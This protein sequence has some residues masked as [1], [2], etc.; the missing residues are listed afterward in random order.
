MTTILLTVSVQAA[1]LYDVTVNVVDENYSPVANTTVTVLQNSIVV[2]TGVTDVSGNVVFQLSEGL[3]V[4]QADI[5]GVTCS[6]EQYINGDVGIVLSGLNFNIFLMVL[7]IPFILL[8]VWIAVASYLAHSIAVKHNGLKPTIGKWFK[9]GLWSSLAGG[10]AGAIGN[11]PGGSI[12]RAIG[13]AASFVAK[14]GTR[15]YF[16]K[17]YYGCSSGTAANIWGWSLALRV[18]FI[19]PAIGL[20]V[21]S[22]LLFFKVI[23]I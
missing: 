16:I 19:I 13:S 18:L 3:Y 14:E 2:T 20:W 7:I 22:I 21:L 1:V 11:I 23:L 4:F 17:K 12:G 5:G 15:Y 8:L 10:A 9:T 6:V